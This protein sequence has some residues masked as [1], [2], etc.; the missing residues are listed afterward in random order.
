VGELT[1]LPRF[2]SWIKER[3]FGKGNGGGLRGKGKGEREGGKA[4]RGVC[5]NICTTLTSIQTSR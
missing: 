4:R 1:A 3:C 2:L 5:R